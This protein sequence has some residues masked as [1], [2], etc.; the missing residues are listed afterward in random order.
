MN[1]LLINKPV[2]GHST[3]KDTVYNTANFSAHHK[4]QLR[5]L[6]RYFQNKMPVSYKSFLNESGIFKQSVL[7]L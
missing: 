2:S 3:T 6:L 1:I 4:G 7:T 5:R